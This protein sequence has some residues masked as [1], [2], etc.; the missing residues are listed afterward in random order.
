MSETRRLVKWWAHEPW[1]EDG[2]YFRHLPGG[3]ERVRAA[4][5][6][7]SKHLNRNWWEKVQRDGGPNIVAA[8]LIGKGLSRL[9]FIVNLGETLSALE[10][11]RGFVA[12]VRD[13]KGHKSAAVLLELQVAKLFTD[14][15]FVVAFPKEGGSRSPDLIVEGEG[16]RLA[17]ECKH[18]EREQWEEW[19]D[20][21]MRR[22]VH[23][24]GLPPGL[25]VN[26]EL[27]P[28]LSE[29]RL[30]D[31]DCQGFTAFIAEAICERTRSS[32]AAAIARYQESPHLLPMKFDVPGLGRGRLTKKTDGAGSSVT[33]FEIS[34]V[35]QLRRILTNG[36]LRASEQLP[37]DRP[38]LV[39]VQCDHMP[40]PYLAHLALDAAARADDARLGHV[41]ALLILPLQYLLNDRR[42]P[43]LL[44]NACCRHRGGERALDVVQSALRPMVV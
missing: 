32:V 30:Q 19:G 7:L 39:V 41:R 11:A 27:E 1:W 5:N 8:H 4:V 16:G 6:S 15:G 20:Q 18:L 44:I 25:A 42:Q 38:G 37:A 40:E 2:I 43:L 13:L 23:V 21:L 33:G 26:V 34:P 36:L 35:A 31:K 29:I 14:A 28:R 24:T 3:L 22:L 17:V 12:K 9:A 10:K